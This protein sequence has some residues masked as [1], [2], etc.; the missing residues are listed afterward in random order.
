[1]FVKN[2]FTFVDAVDKRKWIGYHMKTCA[3]TSGKIGMR[4]LSKTIWLLISYATRHK[5]AMRPNIYDR[6]AM[7]KTIAVSQTVCYSV[8]YCT[9]VHIRSSHEQRR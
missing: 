3:F 9:E 2:R 6:S 7:I 5:R 4:S 8:Q 1:M